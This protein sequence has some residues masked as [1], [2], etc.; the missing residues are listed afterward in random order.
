MSLRS[1]LKDA[2]DDVAP[3]APTLERR[4]TAFVSADDRDRPAQLNRRRHARWSGR[5]QGTGA[6]VAAALVVALMAGLA[7]GGR[8]GRDL[9]NGESSSAYSINQSD[10]RRLESI[11][12]ALPLLQPGAACPYSPGDLT[13]SRSALGGGP[14]Y[15]FDGWYVSITDRVDWVAFGLYYVAQRP[16]PVLVRAT[17][18][19]SGQRLSFSQYPLGDSAAIAVGPVLGT[20]RLFDRTIQLHP[21]AALPDPWHLPPVNK[22]NTAPLLS[23]M[24]AVPRAT[25]CWGFQIDGPGFTETIVDGWDTP[26]DKL[27]TEATAALH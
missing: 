5:F 17:D 15:A 14:V 2:L 26:Q 19:H 21:E 25:L 16:G 7:I 12:I 23:V 10:L 24:F 4:V 6:L 22:N 20:D 9:G 1:Q 13:V 11:P 8:L 27:A 18:L 3:P